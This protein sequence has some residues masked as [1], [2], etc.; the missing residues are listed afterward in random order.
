[1]IGRIVPIAV[2]VALGILL[3]VGLK[4]S[5]HK[6]DLPSPLIGKPMP[7]FSLP[8]LGQESEII[9]SDDLI[10]KPFLV[11][12]WASWCVTCRAEHP[13]IEQLAR[14]GVIRVIGLNFRDEPADAMAW[15]KR[16]GNPYDLTISDRSGRTS[17]DF[18]VYA[19]PESF[20]VDSN[21]TIVY[22][23]LGMITPEVIQKE[24]LPRI[25]KQGSMAD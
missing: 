16:H 2:F 9:N 6:E 14:S 17:I 4:I 11:N 8:V 18:G 19:A 10:G 7:S 23:Q 1:M 25:A 13:Y 24:I 12:F 5:D 22:K 21:G 3:A 15:L 20:L